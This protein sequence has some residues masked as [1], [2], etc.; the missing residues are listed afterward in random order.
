[1]YINL[2]TQSRA[3]MFWYKFEARLVPSG[4]VAPKPAP[5]AQRTA[6]LQ[7]GIPEEEGAVQSGGAL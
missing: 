1:M 5:L 3:D 6:A 4:D 2:T 7:G